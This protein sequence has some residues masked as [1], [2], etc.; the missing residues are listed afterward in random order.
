LSDQNDFSVGRVLDHYPA[1]PIDGVEYLAGHGGFSGARIWRCRAKDPDAGRETVLSSLL[2][3]PT[4]PRTTH[5]CL[6][7]WPAGVSNRRQIVW[8]HRILALARNRGC[9]FLPVPYASASG[10]TLVAVA[11]HDWELSPWMPGHANYEQHPTAVRRSA[12]ML[13]LAQ[14]HQAARLPND[15]ASVGG[16]DQPATTLGIVR[17]WERL[18]EF[19][20]LRAAEI[21]AAVRRSC[22]PRK[23]NAHVNTAPPQDH[24]DARLAFE[25]LDLFRTYAPQIAT[26]VQTAITY[27]DRLVHQPCIGDIWHDHVL[28]EG[29]YVSGIV[30]FGAMRMDHVT[31]DVARLLGSLARHNHA[32][33]QDGLAAYSQNRPLTKQ[34][35]RVTQASHLV[36]LLL[37]GMNWLYWLWVEQRT[38]DDWARV[39]ARVSRCHDDQRQIGAWIDYFKA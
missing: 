30:D 17:K 16:T 20:T 19:Q 26:T 15:G 13:A 27:G 25:M 33:W 9:R 5:H 11:D 23:E 24:L 6:R 7:R 32:H 28:Y 39:V 2:I 34:E 10:P 3:D 37:S 8:A 29:D 38:F 21:D 1:I 22:D 4:K 36:T 14:F 12:A 35:I 31:T 18:Q